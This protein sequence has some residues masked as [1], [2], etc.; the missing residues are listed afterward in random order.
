MTLTEQQKAEGWI[1]HDGGPCPV[2]LGMP[3]WVIHRDE[4][5]GPVFF[6]EAQWCGGCWKHDG[7][8]DD[9]IAYREPKP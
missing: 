2:P 3:V 9:I 4:D 1:E 7:T 5:D 6:R 8:E